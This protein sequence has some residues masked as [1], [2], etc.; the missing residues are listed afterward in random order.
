MKKTL[1]SR[2]TALLL[3][4]L[5]LLICSSCA[6]SYY[7]IR[8]ETW[9]SSERTSES[10]DAETRVVVDYR[11]EYK[12]VEF[13]S[14]EERESWREPLIALLSKL[15]R[16]GY[17]GDPEVD[18]GFVFGSDGVGLID[19]NCDGIP[20]VAE[21]Y[22]GGSMMNTEYVLYDLLTGE[23]LMEFT[24]GIYGSY[25][26][27]YY[28]T[29][30]DR[31]EG[32]YRTVGKGIHRCGW[33]SGWTFVDL[34]LPDEGGRYICESVLGITADVMEIVTGVAT[35]GSLTNLPV[36][37]VVFSIRGAKTDHESYFY[38]LSLFDE[39]MLM[40]PETAMIPLRWRDFEA[41]TQE[42]CAVLVAEALLSSTQEFVKPN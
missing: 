13:I 18:D 39:R 35:D 40:I 42:T 14:D 27:G 15:Q 30:F 9:E 20:E 17:Y 19:I 37:E 16:Y 23:Q 33:S 22:R 2:V 5:L 7:P 26:H 29:A 32:I 25:D 34:F 8:P 38:A 24:G 21:W 10:S 1:S 28:A 4:V 6:F 41:E 31:T 12:S 36:T 11:V 3:S